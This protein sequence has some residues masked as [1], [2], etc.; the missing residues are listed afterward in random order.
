[1]PVTEALLNEIREAVAK[2]MDRNGHTGF[3]L[4]I[5]DKDPDSV[6][7]LIFT[8]ATEFVAAERDKP[9]RLGQI[10]GRLHEHGDPSL[11]VGLCS[12]TSVIFKDAE[13]AEVVATTGECS[14]LDMLET[15][16]AS[17]KPITAAEALK[18]ANYRGVYPESTTHRY[19]MQQAAKE[20]PTASKAAE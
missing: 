14:A 9:D 1:M 7:N 4:H 17:I 3:A 8:V 19:L 20:L 18:D 11:C 2:R 13:V 15:Y 10:I 6:A 5:R 16:L 12:H